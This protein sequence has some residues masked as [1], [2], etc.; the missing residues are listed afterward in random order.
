MPFFN[1]WRPG[2]TGSLRHSAPDF[3]FF[4]R[5]Q[6]A[7]AFTVGHVGARMNCCFQRCGQAHSIRLEMPL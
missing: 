7:K 4:H 6:R 3:A 1:G 2:G 5:I